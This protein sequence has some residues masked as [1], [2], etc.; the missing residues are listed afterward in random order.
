MDP[1]IAFALFVGVLL[2]IHGIYAE[3]LRALGDQ[4]RVEY[5]FIPRSYYEEQVFASEFEPKY[6]GIFEDSDD[7]WSNRY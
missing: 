1:F 4:A 7:P 2:L 3:K 6:K 5:R